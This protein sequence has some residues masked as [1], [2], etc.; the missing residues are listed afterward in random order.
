M[1]FMFKTFSFILSDIADA[2]LMQRLFTALFERGMILLTTSN[3][4]P[5]DLYKNGLQRELFEPFIDTLY[6][7]C[8]VVNLESIDYRKAGKLSANRV[9]F[10]CDFENHL[11][12]NII[13]RQISEQDSSRNQD[14]S[15]NL[16]NKFQP[17]AIDILG[18][19][20]Y[21]DRTYK[22]ILETNF[23]FMC[24]EARS[25]VDYI[26]L[27]KEFDVIVLRDIPFIDMKSADTLR[28]FIV[29]IDTVYDNQV[30]FIASGK[31]SAP[32]FIFTSLNSS[33]K[34]YAGKTSKKP[35]K[36]ASLY[37]LEEEY[38]A[39]ER[40]ISRLLDMQTDTYETKST[41]L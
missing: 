36:K 38:F 25:A 40:T 10:N 30:K 4:I 3:R 15:V 22:R 16:L 41:R 23:K 17:R 35:V 13:V 24:E 34:D 11:L 39:V 28:R 32:Q 14:A 2:M 5:N 12:E 6:K 1:I 8:D 26:E 7:Y 18:R 27:C 21:L 37:T 19:S 9:Y 29:L 31:A 20:V 33:N